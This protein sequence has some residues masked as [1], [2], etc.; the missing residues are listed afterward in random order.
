M[1]KKY[2]NLAIQMLRVIFIFPVNTK[3]MFTVKSTYK[4]I[5]VKINWFSFPN[6]KQGTSHY[7]FKSN[8]GK[9]E[10]I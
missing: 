3:N 6:L 7:T 4:E 1:W 5:L 8:S 9:K 10:Q 2:Q